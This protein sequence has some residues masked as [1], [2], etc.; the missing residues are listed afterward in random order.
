MIQFHWKVSYMQQVDYEVWGD[1]A[2]YRVSIRYWADSY[3]PNCNYN[4]GED[5]YNRE[6]IASV[7]VLH[8][9]C[10]EMVKPEVLAAFR[11]Y[12]EHPDMAHHGPGFHVD[13][14]YF[15][16]DP[17]VRT[18]VRMPEG[19]TYNPKAGTESFERHYR[20]YMGPDGWRTVPI[21]ATA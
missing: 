21:G 14:G 9:H 15:D 8:A 20:C 4:G 10:S 13:T 3:G 12:L 2:T 17:K 11:A 18:W 19:Y 7:G 5:R 16:H 6:V 1:G